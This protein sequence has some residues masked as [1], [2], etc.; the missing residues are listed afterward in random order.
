MCFPGP[1]TKDLVKHVEEHFYEMGSNER[2]SDDQA[3]TVNV[4]IGFG[5]KTVGSE[6]MVDH[7]VLRLTMQRKHLGKLAEQIAESTTFEVQLKQEMVE[8]ADSNAPTC[9]GVSYD[10]LNGFLSARGVPKQS[11]RAAAVARARA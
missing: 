1:M 4:L 5:L 9:T 6:T 10:H 2:S 11:P 8:D 7:T 3:R